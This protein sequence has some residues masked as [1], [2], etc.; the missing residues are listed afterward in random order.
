ML[1]AELTFSSKDLISDSNKT[2]IN[3]KLISL[4]V[5]ISLIIISIIIIILIVVLSS[6]KSNK[7]EIGQINC[8]YDVK[9][10]NKEINILG[11]EFKKDSEFDMFI[12]GKLIKYSKK[13]VFDQ[14][15]T[16]QIQ[17]KLYGNLNMDFMFKNIDSLISIEM[18]SE[19]F[20]KINTMVSSFENCI[21]LETFNIR[22][23]NTSEVKSFS[24]LFF[25]TSL[26]NINLENFD[27]NNT[28]D[29]SYMFAF[30][31]I[32]KI[33]ISKFNT[34]KAKNMSHMFYYCN[35]L[36]DLDISNFDV[37]NVEDISYMF[38]HCT[39][40]SY[41]NLNNFSTKNV[42]KYVSSF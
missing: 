25:N 18:I 30:S 39:K 13:Y 14:E 20:A 22:G 21:N 23:F 38:Y 42:Q 15:K 29:F 26:T 9:I 3:K 27:T 33:N 6:S 40:I 35:L 32:E 31:K 12:D 24:K 5:I 34:K 1:E 2:K 10:K 19:K 41:L 11:E 36:N 8:N 4:I 37:N 17:F 16:Y 7:T 28:E